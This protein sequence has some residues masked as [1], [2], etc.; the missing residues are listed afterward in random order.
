M[1]TVWKIYRHLNGFKVLDIAK[2]GKMTLRIAIFIAI[3]LT[4]YP[5]INFYNEA[6]RQSFLKN[7]QE[8]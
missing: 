2:V 4:Q 5:G 1:G 8:I 7:V 3:L 6:Q